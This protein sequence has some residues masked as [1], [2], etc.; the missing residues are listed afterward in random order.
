MS[1]NKSNTKQMGRKSSVGPPPSSQAAQNEATRL[2]QQLIHAKKQIKDLEEELQDQNQQYLAAIKER[3]AGAEKLKNAKESMSRFDA[4]VKAQVERAMAAER[5]EYSLL[6]KKMQ[7]KDT[8]LD[9]LRQAKEHQEQKVRELQDQLDDFKHI[10]QPGQGGKN[11]SKSEELRAQLIKKEKEIKKLSQHVNYLQD[12]IEDFM[13]ENK[14]LRDLSA[15]PD[16]FGI[17]REKVRLMDREKIDDYKKLVRILQ[18]DNYL[19]EQERAN[20][21]QRIKET[22]MLI[23]NK[24][25]VDRYEQFNLK[26]EQWVQLDQYVLKLKNDEVIEPADIYDIKMQNEILKAQIEVYKDKDVDKVRGQMELV[27][28]ELTGEGPDGEKKGGVLG[29]GISQ[30]QFKQILVGYDDIKNQ[31]NKIQEQ[32]VAMATDVNSNSFK[33]NQ[34]ASLGGQMQMSQLMVPGHLQPPRPTINADGTINTGYSFRFDAN[35]PVTGRRGEKEGVDKQDIDNAFLQLQLLECFEKIDKQDDIMRSQKREVDQL[36]GRIQR[37]ILM[38]DHLY[39]DYVKLEKKNEELNKRLL[40]KA[41][42]DEE[43]LQAHKKNV[44]DLENLVAQLERQSGTDTTKK[45]LIELKKQN[46]ILE[47]NMIQTTRKY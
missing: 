34:S 36:Y 3:D 46:T 13:A 44:K 41:A 24:N 18:E 45:E 16:N 19:L 11:M 27:L 35:L 47:V 30:E 10:Q 33:M 4:L 39:R 43:Q 17:D 14:Q 40:A 12:Q 25:P 2:R 23:N 38:Q 31:L 37:Y 42:D 8:E 15:V 7:E 29:G 21:K 5:K 9:M 26:P 1:L 32:G 6:Q 22:S 20:L 28:K